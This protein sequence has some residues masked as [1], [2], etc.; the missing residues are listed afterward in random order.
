MCRFCGK[1]FEFINAWATH[2]FECEK[3]PKNLTEAM[4]YVDR[5]HI[6]MESYEFQGQ[7]FALANLGRYEEAIKFYD[8]ALEINPEGTY[9]LIYKGEA[10]NYLGKHREAIECFDKV[11]KIDPENVDAI[12]KKN[13]ALENLKKHEP[14]TEIHITTRQEI[15]SL[16]NLRPEEKKLNYDKTCAFCNK[17]IVWPDI[18]NCYYCKKQFCGEHAQ[19]ENHEDPKVMAAKHIKGDYLREKGVNISTGRYRI[20][21]KEH[22]FVSDYYDIE[23]ANQKRIEHIKEYKCQSNSVWLREHDE[24]RDADKGFV[25]SSKTETSFGKSAQTEWLYELLVKAQYV[26]N[27]YHMNQKDFFRDCEF[28][29]RFDQETDEAFGYLNGSFPIY[30]IGIHELF[31]NPT[32]E[33]KRF[34]TMTIVH[35]LLHAIHHDWSE[36]QVR[37]EEYKLANLAGYF[38]TLQRRDR[39]YL[40]RRKNLRDLS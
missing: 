12:T 39:A 32:D 19:P 40:K 24:D 28:R 17:K 11:L 27:Q 29:F 10:L 13:T 36:N 33:D 7:G 5:V 18:F 26:I 8:K 9:T 37:G 20:E 30:V 35:E 4:E 21:C 31:S 34:V 14:S 23:I 16:S 2:E 38:D 1:S 15:E 3:N 25:A 22:G 6:D